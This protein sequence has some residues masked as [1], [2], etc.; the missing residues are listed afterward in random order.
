MAGKRHDDKFD[1][2]MDSINLLAVVAT[3]CTCSIFDSHSGMVRM[4]YKCWKVWTVTVSGHDYI[5]GCHHKHDYYAFQIV[6][7]VTV[8]N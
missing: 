6:R 2:G 1:G 3:K 7:K 5:I 8:K 4:L